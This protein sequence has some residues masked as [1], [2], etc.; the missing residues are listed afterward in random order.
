MK[1]IVIICEGETEQEFCNK[2]LTP[3]LA[4]KCIYVY[5]PLIKHTHGGIVKWTILKKQ[6]ESNLFQDSKAYVTLFVDY[7]GITEEHNFPLWNDAHK[8]VNKIERIKLLEKGM[9]ED[10]NEELNLRFIPYMQL[11]EFESLLF[12]DAN[13]VIDTIDD[14]ELND[15]DDFIALVDNNPNPEMINNSKV[16][17]PSHRMEKYITGYNKIVYGN[18]IAENIGIDNMRKKCVHFN[19]WIKAIESIKEL[20]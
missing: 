11:H 1:R 17:S 18:I 2:I 10:V 4:S 7:Y 16:T 8:I 13:A 19:E 9:C 20:Q 3:Y 15:K 12:C 6:I 14:D 5:A